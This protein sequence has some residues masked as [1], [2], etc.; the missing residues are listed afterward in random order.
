MEKTTSTEEYVEGNSNNNKPFI[1]I[2]LK[3]PYQATFLIVDW[4][5]IITYFPIYLYIITT[6]V[7]ETILRRIQFL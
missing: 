4:T 3:L 2:I 7:C 5:S 6:Q 1:L